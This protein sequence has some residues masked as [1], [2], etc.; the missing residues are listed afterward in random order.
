MQ[1][2]GKEEPGEDRLDLKKW[3]NYCLPMTEFFDT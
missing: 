2:I 3:A 1:V